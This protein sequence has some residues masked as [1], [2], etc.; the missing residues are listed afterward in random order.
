MTSHDFTKLLHRGTLM[1]AL[2]TPALG[3]HAQSAPPA[4]HAAATAAPKPGA[5]AQGVVNVNTA[6]LQELTRLPKIGPSR[7]QAILELRTKLGG[8]K[9]LE[10]L[11]RVKGIGRKTFRQLEPMLSLQGSTTL[12]A[13]P[14]PRPGT[15]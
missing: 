14:G 12:V 11:M 1:L 7:A 13:H 8:F 3:A 9:K 15:H 5:T 10:D 2:L 6:S 4:P